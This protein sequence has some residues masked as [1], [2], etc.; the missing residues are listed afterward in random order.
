MRRSI[1]FSSILHLVVLLLVYF[2]M[3]SLFSTDEPLDRP[4]PVTVYPVRDETVLPPPQA[5]EAEPEVE[6]EPEPEKEPLPM[7]PSPDV[8]DDAPPPPPEPTSA[9]P[10]PRLAEAAA[11]PPPTIP[12]PSVVPPPPPPK[13]VQTAA[14]KPKPAPEAVPEEKPA[15]PDALASLLKSLIENTQN[16][17]KQHHATVQQNSRDRL[18]YRTVC[19]ACGKN[20][21][22]A[23]H[24]VRARNLRYFVENQVV[25]V[26]IWLARWRC[27]RCGRTFTDYPPFRLAV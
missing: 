4:I 8:A 17:I 16:A 14:V 1:T 22:F 2:G 27:R 11:P 13:P 26:V 5:P 10:A 15:A 6:A 7:P 23:P 24:Q 19:A 18:C 9:K 12:E 20:A 21:P 25:C 3:P